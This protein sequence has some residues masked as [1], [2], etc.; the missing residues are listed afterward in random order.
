MYA[1]NDFL[2]LSFPCV[3]A[4]TIRGKAPRQYMYGVHSQV[5]KS[6]TTQE[7]KK[8]IE[9]KKRTKSSTNHTKPV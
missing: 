1:E 5:E 9:R 3:I 2:K 7:E 6:N 8:N 4:A